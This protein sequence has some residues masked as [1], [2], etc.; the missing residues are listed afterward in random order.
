MSAVVNSQTVHSER[1]W[2]TPVLALCGLLFFFALH[3]KIAVYNGDTPAKVTP[4]T[5]AKFWINGQKMQV[6][7][8]DSSPS[9]LFSV[10]LF[11]LSGLYPQSLGGVHSVVLTAPHN[12]RTRR[13]QRRFLR[14]PP[15]QA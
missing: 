5:A 7:S 11:C 15:I 2:H 10:A 1:L 12:D 9:A 6:R 3:A 13:Y 14:P 8:F 4:S